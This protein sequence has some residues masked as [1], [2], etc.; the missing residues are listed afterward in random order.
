MLHRC[1]SG[2]APAVEDLVE[3]LTRGNV[4]EV[5]VLLASVAAALAVYQL[6]LIAVG[7]GKLRL[8]FL[9]TRPA[10]RTHRAVGDTIVVLVAIVGAMCLA[11]HG[12]DDGGGHGIAGVLLAL[13]LGAKIAVVRRDFGLGRFLPVFGLSVFVLLAAAWALSAGDFL[14]GGGIDE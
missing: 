9:A 11:V 4:A 5:K 13:V 3:S 14:A 12:F 8:P 10:S 6:L 7:Y 1:A 2:Y